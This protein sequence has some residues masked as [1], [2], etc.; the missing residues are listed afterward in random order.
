MNPAEAKRRRVFFALWPEAAARRALR[1]ARRALL[2]AISGGRWVPESNWHITL[3]FLGPVEDAI[4]PE[5][6]ERA[7]G[8]PAVEGEL[9]LDTLEYWPRPRV[10]CLTSA[11]T[12]APLAELAASLAAVSRGLGIPME[13]R[14]YRAHLTLMRALG[15]M[16]PE[17]PALPAVPWS[18][19]GFALVESVHESGGPAYPILARWGSQK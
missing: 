19:D 7:A 18:F 8:L 15:H 16:P 5:L 3:A 6:C 14:P 2:P 12:P 4:L 13:N 9:T 11:S 1:K 10:L 17:L